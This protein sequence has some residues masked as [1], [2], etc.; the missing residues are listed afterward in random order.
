M[1]CCT[2]KVRPELRDILGRRIAMADCLVP[3]RT[4][5]LGGTAVLLILG[6][7]DLGYVRRARERS[8]AIGAHTARPIGI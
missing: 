6:V 1:K 8:R 5:L 3:L 4:I 7:L 2:R